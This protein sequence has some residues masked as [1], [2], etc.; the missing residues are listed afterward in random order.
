MGCVIPKITDVT[1]GLQPALAV[2]PSLHNMACLSPHPKKE[3]KNKAQRAPHPWCIPWP[4]CSMLAP[5]GALTSSF[6]QHQCWK[7]PPPFPWAGSKMLREQAGRCLLCC[8]SQMSL[9]ELCLHFGGSEESQRSVTLS[10]PV[11]S[12][13]LSIEDPGPF[14]E[15]R[16]NLGRGQRRG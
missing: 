5:M 15:G 14:G 13:C 6:P 3:P 4:S 11:C 16:V 8:M 1:M 7:H 9:H 10:I 12:V 2:L